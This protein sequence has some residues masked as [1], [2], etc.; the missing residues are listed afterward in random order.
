MTVIS[1]E[2]AA[3]AIHRSWFDSKL[4]VITTTLLVFMLAVALLGYISYRR[5]LS[6]AEM[7]AHELSRVIESDL[8]HNE[9]F[10]D[11]VSVLYLRLKSGNRRWPQLMPEYDS[12]SGIYGFNLYADRPNHNFRGT[13]QSDIPMNDDAILIAQAVDIAAGIESKTS[14]YSKIGRRYFLSKDNAYVYFVGKTPLSTYIFKSGE[15]KGYRI[16][17]HSRSEGYLYLKLRDDPHTQANKVSPVYI[18]SLSGAPV[19]TVQHIVFDQ[20]QGMKD[21]VLGSLCFDY[22]QNELQSLVSSLGL[23]DRNNFLN[24]FLLD[25]Q[26]NTRFRIVGESKEGDSKEIHSAIN[27]RYDVI[28][29]V[30]PLRYYLTRSGRGDLIVLMLLSLCFVVVYLI[31]DGRARARRNE[32]LRDP[33]TGLYNRGWLKQFEKRCAPGAMTV[34]MIDCDNFKRINDTWGHPAGDDALTH[35]SRAISSRLIPGI[36]F[37]VRMGGDEFFILFSNDC[38]EQVYAC[39]KRIAHDINLFSAQIPLS[40][41]YGVCKVLPGMALSDAIAHADRKMYQAKRAGKTDMPIN[42]TA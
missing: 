5:Q 34:A 39:M 23:S 27:D 13:L 33:L 10:T 1:T 26:T 38:E 35:I 32:S 15:Q 37:A 29:T 22:Q 11:A 18:D 4:F 21:R 40:I 42:I 31:H 36:D 7:T 25:R 20:S 12:R 2:Q 3:P 17:P 6:I 16:F 9:N 14:H 28:A 19:I 30:N 24:I 8:Y 41:S